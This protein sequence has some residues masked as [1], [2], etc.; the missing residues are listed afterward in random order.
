MIEDID[1]KLA[2]NRE[3][4]LSPD[5]SAWERRKLCEE[6]ISLLSKKVVAMSPESHARRI[7]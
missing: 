1:A 2:E 4:M 6:S 7:L 3:K 5:A